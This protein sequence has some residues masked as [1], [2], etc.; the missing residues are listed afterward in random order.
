M[1]HSW[2][3]GRMSRGWTLCQGIK[4]GT[5]KTM[6]GGVSKTMFRHGLNGVDGV[7]VPR[8][9]RIDFVSSVIGSFG[10]LP[11][12]RLPRATLSSISY[13]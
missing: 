1:G 3:S 7:D 4:Y 12:C 8:Q 9:V 13:P 2:V 10:P 6:I 5:G 11:H